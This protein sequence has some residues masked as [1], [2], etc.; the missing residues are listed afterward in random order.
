MIVFAVTAVIFL[1]LDAVMLSLV[2]KPLFTRHLG[3]EMREKP[4]LG[5]A[6]VFYLAYVAG[7]VFLV[8][9]P[10]LQDGAPERAALHGAVIGAMAYGT[11]EFTSMAIMKRWSWR[12]VVTDTIWGTVLTGFSAWA[13]VMLVLLFRG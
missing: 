5:S 4:M 12:M 11:Y 3:D 6:A 8:S 2:M 10:A 1:A 9:L 7:L 13:G